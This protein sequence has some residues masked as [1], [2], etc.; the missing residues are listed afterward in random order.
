MQEK[1]NAETM[2]KN[3]EKIRSGGNGFAKLLL[4][5]EARTQ[6]NTYTALHEMEKVFTGRH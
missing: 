2:D 1:H 5:M 3:P 6:T 4:V